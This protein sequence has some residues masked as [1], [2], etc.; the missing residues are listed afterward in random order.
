MKFYEWRKH[1]EL[2]VIFAISGPQCMYV[3]EGGKEEG[4]N[5]PEAEG[6]GER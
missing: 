1:L 5:N 4:I 2:T 6:V 3:E